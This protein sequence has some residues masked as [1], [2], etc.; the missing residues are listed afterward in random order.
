MVDQ[1]DFTNQ[2]V[3]T[4]PFA[5]KCLDYLRKQSIHRQFVAYMFICEAAALAGRNDGLKPSYKKFF[6]RFLKVGGASEELPY[7]VPFSESGRV[8]AD[9]W[10][11]KNIAGSYAPSSIRPQAPLRRVVDI[12]GANRNA[13]YSLKESHEELCLEHLLF[14]VPI[15][16]LALAGFL[17]RDH[18]FMGQPPSPEDLVY[19]LHKLLNFT[20]GNFDPS[21]IFSASSKDLTGAFEVTP[22]MSTDQ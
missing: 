13:T 22:H 16:A 3:V 19:E 17:F 18:A 12:F 8:E 7:L 14:G 5:K 15:D 20:P 9:V 4:V 6:H 11:N 21:K 2:F 10:F 1:I